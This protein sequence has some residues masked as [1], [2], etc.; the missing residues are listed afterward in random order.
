[1]NV[2]RLIRLLEIVGHG[3]YCVDTATG[4]VISTKGKPMRPYLV[5]GYEK[6][7][8]YHKGKAYSYRVHELVA[9]FEE[10]DLLNQTVNHID[11]DKRNNRAV[12]LE[13]ISMAEN[14]RHA[15]EL[16]LLN[17]PKGEKHSKL[18]ADEVRAIRAKYLEDKV[19]LQALAAEYEISLRSIKGII[20]RR[21]WK[22][23]YVIN[24]SRALRRS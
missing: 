13:C 18:K 6:I 8:L 20:N 4:T 9:F 23:V 19:T 14:L 22:K 2:R 15:K 17:A 16:G 3:K 24:E 7:K 11:G 12:N 21:T 1:M 5:N 10:Y